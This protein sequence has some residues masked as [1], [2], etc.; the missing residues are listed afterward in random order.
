MLKRLVRL[1]G[2]PF[3]MKEGPQATLDFLVKPEIRKKRAKIAR[4]API[5]SEI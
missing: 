5:L 2:E 4:K 3:K 1:C